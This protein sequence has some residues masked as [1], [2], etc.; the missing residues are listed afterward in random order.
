MF[1][2]PPVQHFCCF[3]FPCELYL[4]PDSY[5]CFFSGVCLFGLDSTQQA[6]VDTGGVRHYVK[7]CTNAILLRFVRQ[8]SY[9]VAL[10]LLLSSLTQGL[11]HIAARLVMA[12]NHEQVQSGLDNDHTVRYLLDLLQ[13]S[14]AHLPQRGPRDEK[15]F[16][17]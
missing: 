12:P 1:E 3:L 13:P 10:A 9:A 5:A 11:L 15:E 7:A 17:A 8:P 14:M 2:K 6:F 4:H 16:I